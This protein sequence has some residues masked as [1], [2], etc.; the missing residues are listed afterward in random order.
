MFPSI[1]FGWI[2]NVCFCGQRDSATKAQSLP[3]TP[4]ARSTSQQLRT[5][6]A[7]VPI[8]KKKK[9]T[10]SNVCKFFTSGKYRVSPSLPFSAT[11][12]Y[13]LAVPKFSTNRFTLIAISKPMQR[14]PRDFYWKVPFNRTG[15]NIERKEKSVEYEKSKIEIFVESASLRSE[16]NDKFTFGV[17]HFVTEKSIITRIRLWLQRVCANVR[18]DVTRAM[19][20]IVRS[21]SWPFRE[22][23]S[24]NAWLV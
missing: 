23:G 15:E 6:T 3:K 22:W 18:S 16:K 11:I 1:L 12:S 9:K 8:K 4:S 21:S 10:D 14:P 7:K 2:S 19:P 13:F 5:S 20:L 24:L 17:I